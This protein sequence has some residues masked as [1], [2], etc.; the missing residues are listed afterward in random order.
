ML[1]NNPGKLCLGIRAT[2]NQEAKDK[3]NEKMDLADAVDADG[4]Y[5]GG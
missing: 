3:S 2:L 5:R 4:S 1:P